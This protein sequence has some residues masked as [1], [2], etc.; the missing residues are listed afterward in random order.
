MRVLC[1][2]DGTNHKLKP[3][4]SPRGPIRGTRNEP[5]HRRAI[6]RAG[7][8][9]RSPLPSSDR[10][11]GSALIRLTGELPLTA[12]LQAGP[13]SKVSRHCQT[14][15]RPTARTP[16]LFREASFTAAARPSTRGI[17]LRS[18][19][20]V[21]TFLIGWHSRRLSPRGDRSSSLRDI[22]KAGI[23]S[24]S[25]TLNVVVAEAAWP[26]PIDRGFKQTEEAG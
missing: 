16:R 8:P 10:R 9:R 4:A 12:L 25:R 24:Y 1:E 7:R 20:L 15:P 26:M 17:W 13:G 18:V 21:G 6:R 3:T 11:E 14:R 5:H 23:G 22:V 19:R 2:G